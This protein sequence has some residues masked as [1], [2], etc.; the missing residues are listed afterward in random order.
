MIAFA[1]DLDLRL[2]RSADGKVPTKGGRSRWKVLGEP[3]CD[4]NGVQVWLER[5][6]ETDLASIPRLAWS[7]L[8]P[9]GAWVLPAAFHD[10]LYR[11]SGDVARL[12]HPDAFTRKEADRLLLEGMKAVGVSKLKRAA[13][14]RA[15]RVGGSGSWG[16]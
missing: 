8:P 7:V 13:I 15:V 16:R 1:G 5:G 11:L 4:W 14:Y 12:N 6:S 3:R 10:A 9:D 2:I